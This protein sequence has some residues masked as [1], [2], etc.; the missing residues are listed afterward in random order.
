[1]ITIAWDNGYRLEYRRGS[2]HN[3][4]LTSAGVIAE[5]GCKSIHE[6]IDWASRIMAGR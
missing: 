5:T 2:G 1:M 6:A 4:R 3:V